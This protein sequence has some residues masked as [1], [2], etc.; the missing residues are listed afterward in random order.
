[1]LA[2]SREQVHTT[3]GAPLDNDSWRRAKRKMEDKARLYSAMKRGDI[4]DDDNRALVDFDRKWAEKGGADGELTEQ[5][6]SE[7]GSDSD[8]EVEMVDFEDE[9]G[10]TRR[11]TRL[12]A[13]REA[14]RRKRATGEASD[15]FTARPVQPASLIYGDAIQ[16]AAFEPDA[17]TA[18][19]MT[20][21]A[22]KRDRELTPPEAVHFDSRE[23]IRTRGTG[24]FAFSR[25]EEERVRQMAALE[26]EREE[27]ERIRAEREEKVKK[28]REEIEERRKK[29][30]DKAGKIFADKF[31]DELGAELFGGKE[32]TDTDGEHE[33]GIG[34]D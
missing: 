13:A 3:N 11:G 25:D 14:A 26:K 24:F 27:T 2:S 22:A 7:D 16:A 10:R 29:I 20:E 18:E 17:I 23:E 32:A 30:K 19:R 28:R 34:N 21:L 5:E 8:G 4:D 12:E 9:F 15:A 1:M 33:P 31:L 6:D